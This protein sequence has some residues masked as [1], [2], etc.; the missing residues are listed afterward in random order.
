MARAPGVYGGA[1]VASAFR[2]RAKTLTAPKVRA[3]RHMALEP[4]L[5]AAKTHIVMNGSVH[6]GILL[7]GMKIVDGAGRTSVIGATGKAIPIAHLVEF[8][9]APHWQPNRHV[10][11]PGARP[12]PFLRPAFEEMKGEVVAVFARELGSL[13]QAR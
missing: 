6:R 9:T 11:H 12:K 1:K 10:M 5:E 7:D 8:G 2:Q 4:M 3:I 13:L